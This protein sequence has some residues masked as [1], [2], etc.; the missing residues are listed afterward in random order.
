VQEYLRM[1]MAAPS[2]RQILSWRLLRTA[3][4]AASTGPGSELTGRSRRNSSS[5][6]CV[7]SVQRQF[8]SRSVQRFLVSAL[9]PSPKSTLLGVFQ[10]LKR[11]ARTSKFQRISER[12]A[13]SGTSRASRLA[14]P[15][16]KVSRVSLH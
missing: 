4:P 10:K 1:P 9:S 13:T 5:E 11:A 2:P 6:R 16:I 12:L 8:M 15:E 3:R 7:G 14:A